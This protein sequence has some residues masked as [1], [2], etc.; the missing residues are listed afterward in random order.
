[1]PLKISRASSLI[2]SATFRLVAQCL[3]NLRYGVIMCTKEKKFLVFEANKYALPC[4]QGMPVA[5]VL[6][7]MSAG[8]NLTSHTIKIHIN[9]I[10]PSTHL[11]YNWYLRFSYS[12]QSFL[13]LFLASLALDTTNCLDRLVI[14]QW[15]PT[16]FAEEFWLFVQQAKS[17]ST[18]FL[19]KFRPTLSVETSVITY[20]AT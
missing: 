8:H 19:F 6:L 20:P 5:S 11:S 4:S 13:G 14:D 3:N 7:S 17:S 9:T 2:Q 1:M 16:L 18:Y 12:G 10:V 15:F